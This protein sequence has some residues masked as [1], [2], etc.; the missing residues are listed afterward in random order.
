MVLKQTGAPCQS[1]LEADGHVAQ[2]YSCYWGKP[3][4]YQRLQL[5]P[6]R[7]FLDVL[8]LLGWTDAVQD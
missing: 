5:E 8:K 6:D 2:F 4:P 1:K 7:S 3:M